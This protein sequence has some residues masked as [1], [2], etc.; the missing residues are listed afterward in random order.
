MCGAPQAGLTAHAVAGQLERVVR[1]Q[2]DASAAERPLLVRLVSPT[3]LLQWD[4]DHR[5]PLRLPRRHSVCVGDRR[6]S[7]ALLF[8]WMALSLA[9]LNATSCQRRATLLFQ[10]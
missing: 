3:A 9:Q 7:C 8:A 4:F 10:D 6:T 1:P 5:D 2:C